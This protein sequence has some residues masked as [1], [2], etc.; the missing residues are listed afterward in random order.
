MEDIGSLRREYSRAGLNREDLCPKPIDQFRLWFE[1]AR[2]A[3]VD[4]PNALSLAT[5]DERG[6]PSQRM[7]LLKAF[8]EKGLVF[9]TNYRSR[10]AKHLAENAAASI[11]F[12]W[13]QLERQLIV[14]GDCEKISTLQ[15]LK[16]FS[17]RPR[18]SRLGAWVSDQSSVI[19]SRK[20]LEMK[21]EEMKRKFGEGE[22]PL[23]DFWGGF[24]LKPRR[25]EFWQG[26]PS[27]L[28][29][30]FEYVKDEKGDWTTARLSP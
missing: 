14:E 15:S 16:Y 11:L 5:V 29:D 8:D 7:V 27:R 13:I 23:P 2:E 24:R 20:I 19:S 12:P 17:S 10:K 26:R 28:H 6:R 9:F 4:E 1:Q 21:L 18:G 22:I 25:F 30:R 3:G